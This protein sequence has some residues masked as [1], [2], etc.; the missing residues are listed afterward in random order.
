MTNCCRSPLIVLFFCLCAFTNGNAQVKSSDAQ[1]SSSFLNTVAFFQNEVGTGL[2][3]YTGKEYISYPAGIKGNPFFESDQLRYGEIFYDGVLYEHIPML[4]D[5]VNQ[6]IIIS[7]YNSDERMELVREKI[8]YFSQNGHHFQNI[9]STEGK[10]ETL[11]HTI[12]EVIFEGN[13][14]VLVKRIKTIKKGMRA[15][16]PNSFV[17]EDEFFIRNQ[18]ALY[19]VTSRSDVMNA[20]KDQKEK[21]KIFIRKNSFKFRKKIEKELIATT[22]YYITLKQ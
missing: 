11:T 16:D 7:R 17:A 4:Y 9:L 22:A 1:Q 5:V 18:N 19:P 6:G 13:T 14:S 20:F 15:E 3:L 21:I 10:D 12:Y 8:K 2:H